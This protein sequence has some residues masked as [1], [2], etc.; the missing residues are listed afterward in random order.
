MSPV[1]PLPHPHRVCIFDHGRHPTTCALLM[2]RRAIRLTPAASLRDD[3][4]SIGE[5]QHEGE[6]KANRDHY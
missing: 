4:I 5:N 6:R 1:T 2:P 3:A